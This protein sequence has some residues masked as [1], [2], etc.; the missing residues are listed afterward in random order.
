MYTYAKYAY[1][2]NVLYT[3]AVFCIR[4][5]NHSRLIYALKYYGRDKYEKNI[6]KLDF[7]YNYIN[8]LIRCMC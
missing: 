6:I 5:G 4:I 8:E 2:H 1:E 7:H 3:C